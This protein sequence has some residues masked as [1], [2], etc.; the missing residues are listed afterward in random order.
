MKKR[1]LSIEVF[2]CCYYDISF[3]F[4]NLSLVELQWLVNKSRSLF[5][6]CFIERDLVTFDLLF[7]RFVDKKASEVKA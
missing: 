1:C 3:S 2:S 5:R 7:V 6:V 4:F